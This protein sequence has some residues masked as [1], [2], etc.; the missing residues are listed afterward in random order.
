[1]ETV[2]NQQAGMSIGLSSSVLQSL[3]QAC[4]KLRLLK[5]AALL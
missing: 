5:P 1:M 3:G 4:L 2:T